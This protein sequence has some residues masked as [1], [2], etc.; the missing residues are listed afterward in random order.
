LQ[1]AIASICTGDDARLKDGELMSN[2]VTIEIDL[3]SI[4]TA[5]DKADALYK[6]V[7][8]DVLGRGSVAADIRSKIVDDLVKEAAYE[9][10]KKAVAAEI[11]KQI[12]TPEAIAKLVGSKSYEMSGVVSQ[13]IKERKDLLENEVLRYMSKSDFK[14]NIAAVVERN[15]ISRVEY[16]IMP[17]SRDEE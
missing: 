16:L 14:R 11:E 6:A 10:M 2:I 17:A 12:G 13:I 3:D 4:I 1:S 7:K 15:L 9:T 8:E 5:K